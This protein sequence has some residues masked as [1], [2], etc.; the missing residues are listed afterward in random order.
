MKVHSGFAIVAALALTAIAP[1]AHSEMLSFGCITNESAQNCATGAL[2]LTVEVLAA[3]NGQVQ[4]IFRNI[5]SAASSIADVYFDDGTLLGLASITNGPGVNFSQGASPG[6]LPGANN[7]S[8][9]FETTAG[10]NADSNPPVQPNGVNPGEALSIFFSLQS[11]GTYAD[12]I[13]ELYSAELRIGIHVQGFQNGSSESFV[14]LAPVP[15]PAA[16]WML[17]AGLGGLAALRRKSAV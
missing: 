3:P 5:G 12:V 11:G 14:N 17:I 9:A 16:A 4:F 15:L 8:P 10:F 1:A 7:I 2:Q 13:R 6:N